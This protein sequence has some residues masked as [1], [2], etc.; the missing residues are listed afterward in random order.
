MLGFARLDGALVE[1]LGEVWVAFSPASGETILL[2]DESA[3]VLEVLEAGPATADAVCAALAADSGLPLE[4]LRPLVNDSWPRL[5]EAGLV[6]QVDTE[7][8]QAA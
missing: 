4:S 1:S 5:I 2:N 3:A 6:R 8:P 7:R